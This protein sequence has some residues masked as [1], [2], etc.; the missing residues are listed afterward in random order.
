VR[1]S[2]AIMQEEIF[3]PLLPIL[4][5]NDLESLTENLQHMPSPL[6]MYIFTQQ[7]HIIGQIHCLVPFGRFSFPNI[8]L[9]HPPFTAFKNRWLQRLLGY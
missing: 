3:G 8:T 6:A 5:Y 7:K 2:D 4:T 1:W 9:H